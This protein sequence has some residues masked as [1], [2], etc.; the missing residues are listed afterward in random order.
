[1]TAL[2]HIA[3][4]GRWA[5]VLAGLAAA[6]RPAARLRLHSPGAAADLETW[7]AAQPFGARVEI[8]AQALDPVAE[9]PGPLLV[10]NRAADHLGAALPALAAGWSILVEKPLAP[11][12]V[13]VERLLAAAAAGPGRLAA[14]QVFLFNPGVEALALALRAAPPLESAELTWEDPAGEQR[15]GTAKRYDPA[16]PVLLDV[17]PHAAAILRRVGGQE[18]ALRDAGFARGGRRMTLD[19]ALGPAACAVS[20]E[21][22]GVARRRLLRVSAG[23]SRFELDFAADPGRLSRDGRDLPVAVAAEGPGPLARQLAAFLDWAEGG[24]WDPRLDPAPGL[25]T[26]RLAEAALARMRP[27]RDRWLLAALRGG[28]RPDDAELAYALVERFGPLALAGNWPALRPRL[29]AALEG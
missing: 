13:E 12:A 14:S 15:H 23:G 5:R 22:D 25:A 20:L 26:A 16:V 28:R 2:L 11:R 9:P 6:L 1:M 27:E 21:R 10:A 8:V 17:L 19:L 3:G 29:M 24:A 4:G 18:P 7:R